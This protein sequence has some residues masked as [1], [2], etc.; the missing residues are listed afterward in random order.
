M[1]EAFTCLGLLK[2]KTLGRKVCASEV[3]GEKQ[4]RHSNGRFR[5]L[6]GAAPLPW[7]REGEYQKNKISQSADVC[8]VAVCSAADWLRYPRRLHRVLL[9]ALV[10]QNRRAP[11]ARSSKR[12]E[13]ES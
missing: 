7:C 13:C 4:V 8:A 6:R 11:L 5:C 9:L 1:P 12:T 3:T 2:L 10:T